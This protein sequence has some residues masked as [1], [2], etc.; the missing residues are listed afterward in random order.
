MNIKKI[1]LITLFSVSISFILGSY[2]FPK[3]PG[4]V[5]VYDPSPVPFD[6]ENCEFQGPKDAKITIV[7]FSDLECPYSKKAHLRINAL[8]NK[9]KYYGK[10]KYYF[11]S[12]P[13]KVHT[14][15]PKMAR[16]V[17]AAGRQGKSIEMR[18][19]LFKQLKKKNEGVNYSNAINQIVNDLGLNAEKFQEDLESEE[20]RKLIEHEKEDGKRHNVRAVPTVFINGH[21]LKGTM[22]R[23]KYEALVDKLLL[24]T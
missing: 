20:I 19:E 18:E 10:I 7:E 2:I 16:A 8:V 9:K 12:F 17:L 1:I 3:G 5:I 15:A 23:R 13:L 22:L 6:L 24:K 21:M 14:M 4:S 11:K